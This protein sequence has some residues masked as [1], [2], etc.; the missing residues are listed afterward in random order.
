MAYG[1]NQETASESSNELRFESAGIHSDVTLENIEY[2]TSKKDGQGDNV[3]IFNFRGKNGESFRH[4]EFDVKDGDEGK[5][6]NMAKR[7]RHILT[8]F[9]PEEQAVLSG[10]TF[11]EF[12]NGV[13]KLLGNNN[14]GKSVAIKL[15][16]NNKDYLSFTKY[17][18]FIA[19][20]AK[21]LSIGKNEKIVKGSASP[22]DMANVTAED[23]LPF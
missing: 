1:F 17:L 3:I 5:M 21:D 8:K 12:A 20:E 18:G 14:V 11:E 16:Y 22:S 4:M 23:D 2:G 6:A 15:V 13:V 7:V 9:I 19:K 10:N